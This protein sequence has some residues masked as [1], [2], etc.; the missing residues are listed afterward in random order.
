MDGHQVAVGNDSRDG[1]M[2]VRVSREERLEKF[3]RRIAA[4]F[5]QGVVLNVARVHPGFEG[6]THFLVDVETR[7]ELRDDLLRFQ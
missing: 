1:V 3:D 2:D 7:H 6:F 5:R 4:G